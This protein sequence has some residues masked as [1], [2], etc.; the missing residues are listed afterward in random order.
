MLPNEDS[1][2]RE[3]VSFSWEKACYTGLAGE[4]R[5]DISIE[6]SEMSFP[7]L[8]LLSWWLC[9]V[10]IAS[11]T[12]TG[13]SLL[14]IKK[15]VTYGWKPHWVIASVLFFFPLSV[16]WTGREALL[17]HPHIEECWEK[18]AVTLL[19]ITL[20]FM[21]KWN[22]EVRWFVVPGLSGLPLSLSGYMIS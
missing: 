16:C 19:S 4:R 7:L 10:F 11:T 15:D 6:I 13:K 2:H 18:S 3:I 20:S 21:F 22:N 8:L 1:H 17:T 14:H 12:G 9:S 5:G